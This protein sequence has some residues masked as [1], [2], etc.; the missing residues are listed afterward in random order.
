MRVEIGPKDVA[1]GLFIVAD[2]A[3]KVKH[4]TGRMIANRKSVPLDQIAEV[5]KGALLSHALGAQMHRWGCEI[6]AR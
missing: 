6:G 3:N 4:P 2:L 5:A 1:K